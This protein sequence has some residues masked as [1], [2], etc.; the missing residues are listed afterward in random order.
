MKGLLNFRFLVLCIVFVLFFIGSSCKKEVTIVENRASGNAL[1][2]TYSIIFYDTE[3]RDFSK[4]IDSLFVAMNKSMSTYQSDSD[5]SKINKGDSTVVIDEMFEEVFNLSKKVNKTTNGY[6]DPTVGILVNSW[7]FGQGKHIELDSVKVDSL[8]EFVGFN[9]V[10]LEEDK[11]IRKV[12]A[13]ILFDF[14]AIA[15]GYTVDRLA[16]LLD[17]KGISDYLIEVGGELISKGINKIKNKAFVVGIDNPKA[18]DRT[19]PIAKI[20]L[21]DRAM[22][23]SGNYRHYRVDK[24]T[25]KKFVHTVDPIS[26]FTKNSN[27]LAVSVLAENCAEAD[28]FATSFMAMDLVDSMELLS[29][30]THID[31]YFIYVGVDDQ[32]KF[33]STDGFSN[34]MIK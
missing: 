31:A 33:F 1:G 25:G 30:I 24:K 11:T 22:A 19:S 4:E 28:A 17:Q 12:N 15:K 21:K 5:I 9:K 3:H 2:T 13:N 20:Y 8:L 29:K 18:T 14:N 6:F 27:V 16:V 34:V 7:G 10:K 23:S 26:G 32:I